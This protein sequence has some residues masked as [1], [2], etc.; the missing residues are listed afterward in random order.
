M[1]PNQ[2]LEQ[3]ITHYLELTGLA[4][5]IIFYYGNFTNQEFRPYIEFKR[6]KTKTR[7]KCE[8]F[9]QEILKTLKAHHPGIDGISYSYKKGRG[10]YHA[11]LNLNPEFNIDDEN[12]FGNEILTTLLSTIESYCYKRGIKNPGKRKKDK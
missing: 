3:Q 10:T 1:E 12:Q 4:Q 5:N 6:T 2:K 7:L 8:D 11:H 9:T